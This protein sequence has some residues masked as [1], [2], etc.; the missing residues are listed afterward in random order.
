[1]S[2]ISNVTITCLSSGSASL[3][4]SVLLFLL[5]L[6]AVV[7][8]KAEVALKTP[9]NLISLTEMPFFIL[10][11]YVLSYNPARVSGRFHAII[12]IQHR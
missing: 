10:V 2:E 9:S 11:L 7:F 12:F 5:F 4:N 3:I 6:R 8:V 1:M